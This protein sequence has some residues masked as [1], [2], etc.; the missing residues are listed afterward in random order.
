MTPLR[1]AVVGAGRLGLLHA[2]HWRTVPG[3][4]VV[5]AVDVNAE[6]AHALLAG[7]GE[8]FGDMDALLHSADV[9]IVDI[10]TPTPL[11]KDAALVAARAGKAVFVEK[12]LARTLSDCDAIVHAAAE[13]GVA[14]GVAHVVRFFPAFR[15]AH[16]LVKAGVV[17]TPVTVRTARTCAF[18]HRPGTDWYADPAQSGGVVLDLILHDFDWLLWCFGPVSRVYAQGLHGQKEHAGQRD[19]ALVT[20]R[21]QSGAVGHVCG[22]WAHDG[23]PL[24]ATYEV[25]GDA[26]LLEYDSAGGASVSLTALGTSV[27]HES[28]LAPSDDPYFAELA[29]FADSV[30]N[31]LPPPVPASEA[32]DAVRVALAALES[33]QSGQAVTL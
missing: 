25:C 9:D 19:Y 3:A 33:L 11:H 24:R 8:V 17:G 5:A 1:V 15:Q 27:A 4:S 14:I 26:G 28:P 7:Q 31:N 12:P 18:P 22:S 10:C 6:A 16:E 23:S 29:A 30:R 21:F 13:H 20:L 2:R 32:R